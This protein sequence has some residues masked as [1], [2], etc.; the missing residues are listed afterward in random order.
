MFARSLSFAGSM[1]D[2]RT[3]LEAAVG[4]AYRIERELGHGGMAV[5]FLARDVRHNRFVAIKVVR[6]ELAASL[7]PERFL[8]EIEIA[9]QLHH[10]HILALFDSGA[11]GDLLYYVMPYV[12]GESLRDRLSRERQLPIADALHIARQVASALA[13]ANARGIVH[14]DIKPENILLTGDEAVVADFGI[15]RAI[16]ESGEER[17]T[18]SGVAI[19]TPVYMSP[20]QG[21]GER[22]LDGRSDVYSL[23]C[24]LF[25]TLAGEPPFTGPTALAV[26]AR[27]MT[28]PMPSLRTVRSAV[29]P[30]LE[31]A[32]RRALAP[33]PADRYATAS[34]FADAL[35]A[36]VLPEVHPLRRRLQLRP[37]RVAAIL[38]GLALLGAG[39]YLARPRPRAALDPN[40]IAVAPFEVVNPQLEYLREGIVTV[41]SDNLDGVGPLR[42]VSATV[43]TRRASDREGR[44]AAQDVGRRTHARYVVFGR[45]GKDADS[46]H[47][48]ASWLDAR[49][50][51]TL[52]AHVDVRDDT[53]NTDRA[54]ESLSVALL[55]ELVRVL[56]IGTVP[57][58]SRGTRP[59]PLLRAYLQGEY[60]T[61]RLLWDSVAAYEQQVLTLDSTF[62]PANWRLAGALGWMGQPGGEQYTLR[63]A[64]YN[65]ETGRDSLLIEASALEVLT[66][67]ATDRDSF[68][69]L[70]RGEFQALEEAA[71]RFPNDPEVWLALGEKRFHY[72]WTVGVVPAAALDAFEHSVR[73]DSAFAPAYYHMVELGLELRGAEAAGRYAAAY[74]A[75]G[76]LAP[77]SDPEARGTRMAAALLQ[78]GASAAPTLNRLLDTLSPNSLA[79]CCFQLARWPDSTEAAVRVARISAAS[80]AGKS[81]FQQY[82]DSVD[83]IAELAF[84]GHLHEIARVLQGRIPHFRA[85]GFSAPLFFDMAARGA[86]SQDTVTAL[87]RRLMTRDS[88]Y[89]ALQWWGAVNDTDAL[90]AVRTWANRT[91]RTSSSAVLR[92]R[93]RFA[94]GAAA[95][96]LALAKGDS[97]EA[98]ADLLAT[99][100]SLCPQLFAVR[101]L[102]VQLL[103]GQG[104]E[105]EAARLLDGQLMYAGQIP[106][107]AE[108]LW[109]LERG[110]VNERLGNRDRARTAYRYVADVWRNADPE[111]QPY[112]AEARA[113][114]ARLGG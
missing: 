76:A 57:R 8:R 20:E 40:L 30:E 74:V 2:L 60:F 72:G 13:Y 5:V 106:A 31:A 39:A 45:V 53:A 88:G 47:L 73:L 99:P 56:G 55:N 37:T 35:G 19:G 90:R 84:R 111:L 4:S 92:D 103:S 34:Q 67:H 58:V 66:D 91:V 25:E 110:R 85:W 50:G 44:E 65:R 100:D 64:R 71:R 12:E 107:S 75:L 29:P 14:R 93:A 109:T 114:T 36:P 17:L 61:R 28:D 104:R 83:L 81:P 59:L 7:G 41:L 70:N 15:A 89:V 97:A 33:V 9:A 24:V 49:T 87:A 16:T 26:Q 38:A 68:N 11:V 48:A 108:V 79:G 95:A 62:A 63:A 102:R 54:M 18:T 101:L 32:I 10:P 96:Y 82:S 1:T 43:A 27:R 112:V 78:A 46:L 80:Q 51:A 52:G 3:R 86:V 22:Q 6:P 94:L 42:T 21:A 77:E 98:L 69:A 105:R 113:A 23:G